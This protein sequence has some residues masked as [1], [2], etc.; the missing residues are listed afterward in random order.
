MTHQVDETV[1]LGD[2]TRPDIGAEVSYR[3][4]L[5]DAREGVAAHCFDQ[6]HDLQ[7][8]TPIGLDPIAEVFAELVLEDGGARSG[9][10]LTGDQAATLG[11]TGT[12]GPPHPPMPSGVPEGGAERF[13]EIEAGVQSLQDS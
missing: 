1:L 7:S 10:L 13:S 9:W 3:F 5:A 8:D 11:S 2:S 12:R 6:G 4:G